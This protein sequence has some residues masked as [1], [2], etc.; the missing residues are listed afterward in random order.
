MR[1]NPTFIHAKIRKIPKKHLRN[2]VTRR[3]YSVFE[4]NLPLRFYFF[5]RKIKKKRKKNIVQ[6][7]YKGICW[8]ADRNR[9]CAHLNYDYQQIH[10]GLFHTDLEAAR[11]INGMY[12]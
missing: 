6:S 3:L 8:R 1:S 2:L 7:I 12:F 5:K 9:W 11:A 4:K 10:V